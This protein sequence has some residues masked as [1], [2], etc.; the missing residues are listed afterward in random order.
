M[1]DWQRIL[2]KPPVFRAGSHLFWETQPSGCR[3]PVEADFQNGKS[4]ENSLR[5]PGSNRN[6][7]EKNKSREDEG[8]NDMLK[9]I[10]FFRTAVIRAAVAAASVFGSASAWAQGA[11]PAPLS[12]VTVSDAVAKRT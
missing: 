12:K 10:S 9:H 6:S 7:C 3:V 4:W 2:L 11:T 8:K 1:P 5:L